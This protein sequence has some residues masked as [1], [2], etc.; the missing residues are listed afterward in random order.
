MIRPPPSETTDGDETRMVK[1]NR[2]V[3]A[4]VRTN[5]H[6]YTQAWYAPPEHGVLSGVAVVKDFKEHSFCLIE[7]GRDS[8]VQWDVN[9]DIK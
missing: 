8:V 2:D 5:R 6:G 7:S 4:L 9:L 1:M 3:T